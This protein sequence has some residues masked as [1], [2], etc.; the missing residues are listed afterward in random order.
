MN[1][2]K[3][4]VSYEK[5][6]TS[7]FDALMAEYEAAK[8]YADETVAYYKPLADVAEDA[9]MSAILEQIEPIKQYAKQL[10]QMYRCGNA[11]ITA[12]HQGRILKKEFVV[13][14]SHTGGYKITWGGTIFDCER[15]RDCPHGFTRDDYNI[16]GCWDEWKMYKQLE[17]DATRQ[18]RKLIDKQTSRA[19]D[20]K[21]RLNNIT[22]G[23][24]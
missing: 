17:D 6:T 18:L 9:K 21:N 20:E 16:L 12:I 24:N 14:Y 10:A 8:K 1:E 15:L 5:P 3:V 7:K 23:G 13:C 22:K 11:S 4:T 2:I 19:N